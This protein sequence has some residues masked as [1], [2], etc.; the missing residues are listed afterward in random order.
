VGGCHLKKNGD[1]VIAQKLM[2]SLKQIVRYGMAFFDIKSTCPSDFLKNITHDA[3]M[4]VVP[5]FMFT[6]YIHTTKNNKIP[7]FQV[8]I[9]TLNTYSY[10]L[11]ANFLGDLCFSVRYKILKKIRPEVQ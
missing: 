11:T 7:N 2:T 3:T 1:D 6:L 5:N 10:I 4:N 9:S 8:V